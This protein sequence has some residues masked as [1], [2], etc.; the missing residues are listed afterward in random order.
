MPILVRPLLR[1]PAIT[2]KRQNSLSPAEFWGRSLIAVI[3]LTWGASF[4]IGFQSALSV[5]S[6]ISLAAAIVGLRK[7]ALG[8]F[9]ISMFCTLD[10][11]M[12]PLLLSGGLLRWNTVNY[13]LLIVMLLYLPFLL[14]LS[15]LHSRL[16]QL[17][18]LLLTLEI[19]FSPNQQLGILVILGIV[20][21]LGI[22]VYFVRA[23][24][25]ERN[26]YWLG[27]VCG[28]LAA[29]GG[30]AYFAQKSHLPYINPNDWSFFPLTALFAICL[31]LPHSFRQRRGQ[32]NLML[33]AVT[34]LAWVFLSG[35]RGN[36]SM[37][38]CCLLFLML[39][40]RGI[41][42]RLTLFIAS[43]LI[44]LLISTQ[45]ADLQYTAL[46]RIGLLF[47]STSS[48]RSRTSGRSDLLVGGWLIF[49]DHPFG[50]GTGGYPSA[51]AQI[52]YKEELSNFKRGVEWQ[53]HSGWIKTLAENG[54][55][56]IVLLATYVLSFAVIGW[57]KQNRNSL[58][59][60]LLM[61]TI[62]SVAFISFQLEW[63]K[64]LWFLAAGA[65]VL[66]NRASLTAHLHAAKQRE[67]ILDIVRPERIKR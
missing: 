31:S 32:V 50:V 25:D 49:L 3:L 17:L 12:A 23:S 24:E 56:G 29:V 20:V 2:P 51:W 38:L 60:G 15:D 44:G 28:T 58:I 52:G 6:V 13:W 66:L 39:S 55:L 10:A 61:T 35:S 46:Q 57:T 18:I 22:L 64:G 33:L 62:L 26:W 42:T 4:A 5:L 67:P 21:Q 30:L 48:A 1:Q 8:L 14:R 36:L 16:F 63:A 45:F 19:A 7:P 11:I 27:L 53:A 59:L 41:S 37:A 65:T 9:G 40:L 34:N 54:V 43:A 47:D